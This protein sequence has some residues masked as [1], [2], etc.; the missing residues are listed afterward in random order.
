M[1]VYFYLAFYYK[2]VENPSEVYAE[3]ERAARA[4][5]LRSGGSL[6]H[7]HGIGKLRQEFLPDIMS[8]AALG[9]GRSIK[10]AVDPNNV[11]GAA[12][13]SMRLRD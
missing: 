9:W 12:N 7:H 8:P 10:R 4:E 11:F 13:H 2:G 5:V 6:S 3:V 1:C